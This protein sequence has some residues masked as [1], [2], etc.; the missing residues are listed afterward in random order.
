MLIP[1]HRRQNLSLAFYTGLVAVKATLQEVPWIP[2]PDPE[3][4]KQLVLKAEKMLPPLAATLG[5]PA[6]L[7][8]FL[9][10]GWGIGMA[11][12][13]LGQGNLW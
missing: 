8:V 13:P 9:Q 5:A 6:P 7:K 4:A 12:C 2:N 1:K 11:N 10:W 3:Q